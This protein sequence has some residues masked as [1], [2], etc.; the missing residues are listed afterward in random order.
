MGN[1]FVHIE[2]N[3]TNLSVSKDFYG[4]LFDWKLEEMAMPDG[5]YTSIGVGQG[6]GGGMMHQLIPG[7]PSSW[8]PYVLVDDINVATQKAKT[9]GATVMKDVTPVMDMGWLSILS[10]PAGAMIGLWQPKM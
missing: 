7:A 2:L 1:P 3:S 8:L 10:D 4:K 5:S 6:T 9:L